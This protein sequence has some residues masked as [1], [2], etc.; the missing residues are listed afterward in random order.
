MLVKIDEYIGFCVHRR[1]YLLGSP[2]IAYRSHR[3][4][5]FGLL[6][7]SF[8]V[9]CRPPQATILRRQILV[10]RLN[11]V[12]RATATCAL[13]PFR[14]RRDRLS[15]LPSGKTQMPHHLS[16]PTKK[17][18]DGVVSS[19]PSSGFNPYVSRIPLEKI[20]Q[21]HPKNYVNRSGRHCVN[22][23]S[24]GMVLSK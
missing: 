19:V 5:T 22:G 3:V 6:K 8:G 16:L 12:A 1:S 13:P 2:V 21:T 7:T 20:T 10:G 11:R 4:C 14:C 17:L 24:K 9:R 15:R 18:L 23:S